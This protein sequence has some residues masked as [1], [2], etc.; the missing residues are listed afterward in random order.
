M[1]SQQHP[2]FLAEIQRLD[3]T[4]K[5]MDVVIKTAESSKDQFQENMKEAFQDVD[6]L[7]SSLSYSSLLTN[8]RFFEMSRDELKSLKNARNKPYF[9]RIDFQRQDLKDEEILYIGK[10][11]LYSRE[12]Q[13]QIIVDWRSPIANLYYEGRLGEV[14]YDSYEESF[15]GYLSLKR[16]FM[17]EEG[18]LHEIRDIDLTTTDELLQESLSKSASN[19][20][21]EIIS[22]IQEEQNRIIRAD[23]NKPIIVQGAA[24][25]G[26]TTIALHRISYFIYQYKENFA[27][28]QL[29]ILA[30][31]R[32]FIDYISEALPE[33]GV[34]RV[35]QTTYHEY[36]Q[37][38]LSHQLNIVND[39]KLVRLLEEPESR[40]CQISAWISSAKGSP[41]FHVILSNYLK[42]IY[43]TFFPTK[44]FM[45]DKFRL[46]SY[47]K[48]IHLFKND[49]NYL[50]LFKRLDKLKAV[51]Q[52][53]VAKKK[54]N[55]INKI[56]TFYDERIERALYR[57]QDA[58]KRRQ[59]VS[60]ALDKKALRLDEIKR[61]L[62]NAVPAYMKQFPKKTL[63]QYYHELFD[64]PVKLC[65]WAE[66]GLTDQEAKLL[67]EYSQQ[68][69]AKKK[70]ER[71]DLSLLLYLQVNLFGIPKE[72]KAKNIVIDEAQ[73]YS[74]ME[75]LSLKKALDT[76]MFT[77]VGDLAQGIHSYRGLTSW[78][79]VL[80]DIFP[81]ATYTELQKS[82]RTT[83]EIMEKAN[84][85]LKLLPYS[86]P[87]VEPVV[88]H[89]EQPRFIKRKE[90]K[91]LVRQI[92]KQVSSLK[93]ENYK[94]FAVIGK[95]M[96]DCQLLY[97][98]FKKHSDEP[99]TLLA[100]QAKIP[101]DE[102][103]IVPSFLAKGLE[104]DAVLIISLEESFCRDSELDIKL[105]YVAMTRPLHRLYF[106]GLRDGDFIIV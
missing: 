102:I 12:N 25:S 2:D 101:K 59:Y 56:E 38:C 49:Y 32:L 94:T 78:N 5:Y 26:K 23:L 58:E 14:R 1:S 3:F 30:P 61:A 8:A 84:E 80:E 11:S 100:E 54:K 92:E 87:K 9:A 74:F 37:V 71:E 51:L 39:H 69:F 105:L 27:P 63:L 28:E 43:K 20:L 60:D 76:D 57:G 68:L 97:S 86:F 10:T 6:W 13:E 42:S 46:F 35:R 33:L 89:G 36:V 29:M 70:Y 103:V 50:P 96:K 66:G 90:G 98:L 15:N 21:T 82:Y 22:T 16:Q 7:E 79:G 31:S 95:T 83:V 17:I 88:R 73:D 4:K 24:G 81:R 55:I 47:K 48:F 62:R 93:E 53:D 104:F 72:F 40:D 67:C 106:Y 91:E 85:L 75:L 19:R 34:E 64:D 52:N 65:R 45:V 18:D 77:L 44:D 99:V 41:I